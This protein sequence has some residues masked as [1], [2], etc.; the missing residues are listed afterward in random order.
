[1]FAA[2]DHPGNRILHCVGTTSAGEP[3][4][5]R[6]GGLPPGVSLSPGIVRRLHTSPTDTDL[7]SLVG[8]LLPLQYVRTD[9]T[10]QHLRRSLL[11]QNPGLADNMPTLPRWPVTIVAPRDLRLAGHSNAESLSLRSIEAGVWRVRFSAPE[12]ALHIE[13]MVPPVQASLMGSDEGVGK[14]AG[15]K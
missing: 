5:I 2:I 1:M 4:V 15:S 14:A 11:N 3:V 13:P 7:R 9:T 8:A 6:F 10:S 12:R